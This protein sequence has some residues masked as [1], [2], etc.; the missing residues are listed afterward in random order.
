MANGAPSNATTWRYA[1]ISSFEQLLTR[2]S[3]IEPFSIFKLS[4]SNLLSFINI[5]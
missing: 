3:T 5:W 4:G 1:E 2:H